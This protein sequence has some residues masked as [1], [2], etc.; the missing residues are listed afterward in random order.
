MNKRGE[1]IIVA[2]HNAA[3]CI[4]R[5]QEGKT[6]YTQLGKEGEVGITFPCHS[7]SLRKVSSGTQSRNLKI[8]T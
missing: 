6:E 2:A 8:G 4:E 3:N 5:K 1:R 7:P